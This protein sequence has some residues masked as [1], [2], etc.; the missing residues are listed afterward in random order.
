MSI[1]KE[2][3]QE[4]LD[5]LVKTFKESAEAAGALNVE[6]TVGNPNDPNVLLSID[7]D[8]PEEEIDL[9]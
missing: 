2:Q 3:K 5:D 4:R 8:L 1:T 6:V 7:L 9:E